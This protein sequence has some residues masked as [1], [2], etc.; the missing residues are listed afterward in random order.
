MVTS[1]VTLVLLAFVSFV[2]CDSI[3]FAGIDPG[4]GSRDGL[5]G[6]V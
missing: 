4:D 2:H 3:P 6:D 1:A 5:V